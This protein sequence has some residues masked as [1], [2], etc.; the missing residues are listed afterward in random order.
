[1]AATTR[2]PFRLQAQARARVSYCCVPGSRESRPGSRSDPRL[3]SDRSAVDRRILIP[4]AVAAGVLFVIAEVAY[5]RHGLLC[6]V[7][8][9]AWVGFLLSLL[10]LIALGVVAVFQRQRDRAR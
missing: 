1:M 6:T 5:N 3:G 10:L 4:L 2:G 7:S 8:D 9:L